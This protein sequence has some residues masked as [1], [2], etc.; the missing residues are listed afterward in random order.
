MQTQPVKYDGIS[1]ANYKAKLWKEEKLWSKI[2][3]FYWN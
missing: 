3:V 2:Y 1:L